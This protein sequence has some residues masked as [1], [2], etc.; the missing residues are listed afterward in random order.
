MITDY[1]LVL[2]ILIESIIVKY[3]YCLDLLLP[4]GVSITISI[5]M[6]IVI[7]SLV[8]VFVLIL[9]DRV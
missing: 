3:I 8:T 7:I 9:I 6:L 5:T 1:R 2:Q 4:V